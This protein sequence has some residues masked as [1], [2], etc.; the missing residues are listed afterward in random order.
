[1]SSFSRR[2]FHYSHDIPLSFVDR[3]M[4]MRFR[5]GGVGHTST[6]AATNT[7]LS[8]R[9]FLD[10]GAARDEHEESGDDLMKNILGVQT[11]EKTT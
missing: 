2:L 1:M 11:K 10:L 4:A 3:D 9:D 5:G 6:R 7:F 8:D